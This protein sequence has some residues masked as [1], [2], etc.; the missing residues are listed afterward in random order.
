MDGEGAY[1]MGNRNRPGKLEART[2]KKMFHWSGNQ[3]Q[4]KFNFKVLISLCKIPSS[5]AAVFSRKELA[6]WRAVAIH[7]PLTHKGF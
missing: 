4:N 7:K 2:K 1:R 5:K 3:G 6:T